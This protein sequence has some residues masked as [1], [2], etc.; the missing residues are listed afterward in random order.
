[1]K[2]LYEAIYCNRETP[3][4]DIRISI[5]SLPDMGLP[6]V[7]LVI[8]KDKVP[9]LEKIETKT[10]TG[11]PSPKLQ[12]SNVKEETASS[13]R[14]RVNFEGIQTPLVLK[15][16]DN[17]KQNAREKTRKWLEE[18]PVGLAEV[19]KDEGALWDRYGYTTRR[20]KVVRFE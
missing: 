17:L 1:M 10:G 12:A 16:L 7:R 3:N 11:R 9:L 2:D 14:G 13:N 6:G 18:N 8:K 20:N 15:R 4:K 5:E 19:T